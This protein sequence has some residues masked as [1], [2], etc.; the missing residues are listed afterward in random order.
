RLFICGRDG[1]L[2]GLVL[3]P[4]IPQSRSLGFP[5]AR[6]RLDDLTEGLVG[7]GGFIFR[8]RPLLPEEVVLC[9]HSARSILEKQKGRA[10]PTFSQPRRPVPVHPWSKAGDQA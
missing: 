9:D 3:K 4:C 1:S 5:A 10:N 8:A 7:R 2:L 6:L